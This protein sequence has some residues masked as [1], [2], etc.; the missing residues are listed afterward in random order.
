MNRQK[1]GKRQAKDRQKSREVQAH[2]C[3]RMHTQVKKGKNRHTGKER[4]HRHTQAHAQ[5]R[6]RRVHTY[7]NLCTRT[8]TQNVILKILRIV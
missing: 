2:A 7:L 6:A 3:T 1:T 4:A 8:C 5:A